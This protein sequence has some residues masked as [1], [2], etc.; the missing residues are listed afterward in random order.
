MAHSDTESIINVIDLV[1]FLASQIFKSVQDSD[2][3][4]IN[5]YGLAHCHSLHSLD[6]LVEVDLYFLQHLSRP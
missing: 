4:V 5:H 6:Q 3:E 2:R 1:T